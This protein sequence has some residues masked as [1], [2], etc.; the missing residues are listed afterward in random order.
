MRLIVTLAF[1]AAAL[2]PAPAG[3][4]ESRA[5]RAPRYLG[6]DLY[7][8]YCAVC[9]GRS[10][11]G[12]GPLADQMK[13]RPP[14]L[15]RY[16]QR[17][18]GVF[19]SAQVARIIDGRNPLPGHGGPEMPVWG[20]VFKTTRGADEATVR[21]RIDALVRYLETLQVKTAQRRAA[22]PSPPAQD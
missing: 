21:A 13:T 16:A 11:R 20:D 18:G 2:A 19:P 1:A 12:D 5:E 6:S 22:P 3:A 17:N 7:R 10:G 14:E 8:T 9:H 4:Q 15:T